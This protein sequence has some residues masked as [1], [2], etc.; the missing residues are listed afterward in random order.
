MKINRLLAGTLA[1]VLIA[2]FGSTAFAQVGTIESTGELENFVPTAS[3]D[4]IVYE[5]GTP[6]LPT[7]FTS[8]RIEGPNISAEDFVLPQTTLITDV[9]YIGALLIPGGQPILNYIIYDAP[10]IGGVSIVASGVA[11]DL[12]MMPFS[13]SIT[14]NWFDLEEPFLAEAGVTYWIGLNCSNCE[15]AAWLQTNDDDGLG[16]DL[17]QF[18][19][20][21]WNQRDIG[22]WFQLSGVQQLVGGELLPLETTSLILAGAQSF[23]WMI[24]VVL[25]IIGI[26][27]V[28]VR[29]H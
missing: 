6:D 27:L 14:Q 1:L 8:W 26:G 18:F 29:R 5:N 9:H 15:F 2:G 17:Q 4:P 24:P 20:G 12:E 23:S 7:R 22:S 19:L 13:G 16:Q 25:S 21:T 10:P 3:N 11:Q 28:L